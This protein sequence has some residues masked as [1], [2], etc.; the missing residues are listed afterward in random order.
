MQ[1]SYNYVFF[2][3]LQYLFAYK[4][5]SQIGLEEDTVVVTLEV[6]KSKT[7]FWRLFLMVSR[8]T[9]VNSIDSIY[10]VEIVFKYRCLIL[11]VY[12]NY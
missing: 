3:H 1:I 11:L 12:F 6:N 8:K 9:T 2:L 5:Y 4:T 7:L 10:S